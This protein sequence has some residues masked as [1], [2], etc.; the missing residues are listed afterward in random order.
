[1]Q[2]PASDAIADVA[3]LPFSCRY[4]KQHDVLIRQLNGTRA[5]IQEGTSVTV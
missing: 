2:I 1:M 4:L 3:D 5:G